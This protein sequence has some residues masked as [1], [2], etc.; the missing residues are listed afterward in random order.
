MAKVKEKPEIGLTDKLNP[1]ATEVEIGVR[2]LRKIT[3][4]PLSIGDQLKTTDLISEAISGFMSREDMTDVA[5]ISFI[6]N[7]IRENIAK[8]LTMATDEDGETLVSELSNTQVAEIAEIIYDKNYGEV[9]KN[10][11]SLIGK[12]K[13]LLPSMRPYPASLNDMGATELKTST[14]SPTETVDLPT[15]SSSASTKEHKKENTDNLSS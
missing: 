13:K 7:L 15:D 3:I 2:S 6:V 1:Q 11:E 5:F 4:Y 10:F 12:V 8:I 14:E 9:A